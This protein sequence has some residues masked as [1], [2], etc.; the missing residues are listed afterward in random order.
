MN[1]QK[2]TA[3][4]YNFKVED[5]KLATDFAKYLGYTLKI[6]NVLTAGG[7]SSPDLCFGDLRNVG[8]LDKSY[9][10]GSGAPDDCDPHGIEWVVIGDVEFTDSHGDSHKKGDVIEWMK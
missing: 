4:V 2:I 5:L 1:T 3:G 7:I 9:I 10:P 8:L 6:E